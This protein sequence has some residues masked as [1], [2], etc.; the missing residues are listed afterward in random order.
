MWLRQKII[1]QKNNYF[2]KMKKQKMK[3]SSKYILS[4]NEYKKIK[5]KLF[6]KYQLSGNECFFPP[7]KGNHLLGLE[8]S[9]EGTSNSLFGMLLFSLD[10]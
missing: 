8:I 9:P 4:E 2:R 1:P 5:Y 3:V 10:G 6:I 7:A